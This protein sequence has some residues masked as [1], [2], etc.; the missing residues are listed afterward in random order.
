MI[1]CVHLP[2]SCIFYSSEENQNKKHSAVHQP[3]KKRGQ[4]IYIR[5]LC[6]LVGGQVELGRKEQA[7]TVLV[8]GNSQL[9]APGRSFNVHCPMSK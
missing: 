1:R 3:Q 4:L 6:G 8:Q 9:V 7:K 2:Y 5:Y